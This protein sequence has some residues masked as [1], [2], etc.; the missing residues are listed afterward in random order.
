LEAR[1]P[2]F[3]LDGNRGFSRPLILV[4]KGDRG[5]LA[6]SGRHPAGQKRRTI[7]IWGRFSDR[8]ALESGPPYFRVETFVLPSERIRR[9]SRVRFSIPSPPIFSRIGSVFS[10]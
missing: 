6:R 1:A 5:H 2:L 9:S 3:S 8:T 4:W 10:L 7:K